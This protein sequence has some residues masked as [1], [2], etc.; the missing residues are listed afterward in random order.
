MAAGSGA[1]AE[2]TAL[3]ESL[4]AYA[5][6]ARQFLK[7]DLTK[8]T[9]LSDKTTKDAH[10]DRKLSDC[11]KK[12]DDEW[13][14]SVIVT[15]NLIFKDVKKN[16]NTGFLFYRG[17][18]LPDKIY[19]CFKKFKKTSGISGEDKWN[20]ADI[21]M[22]KKGFKFDEDQQTLKDLNRYLYDE[23]NNN[24][25]IGIS[26]KKVP[27]KYTVHSK[28]YNKGKPD[29]AEFKAFR[30]GKNM[31]DSKDIYIEF[32]SD[33]KDGEVQLRT[34]SS[35]PEPAAWQGE[36]KGKTAAGGKIGGGLVIRAAVESGIPLTKLITPQQFKAEITKPKDETFKKFAMMFKELSG[37]K[38]KLEDLIKQAKAHQKVDKT[39]WLTKFIGINYCYTIM[40]NK[41]QDEVIKWLYQ[42]GSSQTKNSSIFIKY[43]A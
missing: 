37:S 13:Y 15:A 23:F 26:L 31:T 10:C 3:A 12:L 18:D 6:A 1:G 24:N 39:W 38:D 19:A 42:Y 34:F 5:C 35:R 8:I 27:L 11:L 29:V 30:P 25:L 4:Q 17:K 14:H 16:K 41:K 36:I 40:K 7:K 28:I 22:I 20:P 43:S 9:D 2:V 32:V 33:K 21:W